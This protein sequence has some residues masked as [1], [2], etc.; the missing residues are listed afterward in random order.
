MGTLPLGCAQSPPP[1]AVA[2][3]PLPYKDDALEPYI[4]SRTM[5]FHYGKHHKGYVDKTIELIKGTPLAGL[6]FQEILKQT[7]NLPEKT[8]VF[9]NAAQSWNHDFFWKSLRKGGGGKPEG[10]LQ[11]LVDKSFG[12]FAN[13]RKEFFNTALTQ[14]GSGWAWLVLDGD[15]LKVV[16]TA[17]A[18]NPLTKGQT[19]LLTIDVWEHAYYLDYQNR[20]GDYVNALLDHLINWQFAAENLSRA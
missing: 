4:S 5:S 2:F 6:S 12:S 10:D 7:A 14:F 17:N 9:N 1:P 8:A 3:S 15:R 11:T 13:F 18:D 20:R 19:P 16:Q